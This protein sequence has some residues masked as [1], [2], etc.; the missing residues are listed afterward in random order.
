M[1]GA[2]IARP[3][4]SP[5]RPCTRWSAASSGDGYITRNSDRAIAFTATGAEHAEGSSAGIA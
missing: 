2:N 1:T 5:P 4:S 3:C